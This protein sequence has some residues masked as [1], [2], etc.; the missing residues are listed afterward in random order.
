MRRAGSDSPLLH[1]G[2]GVASAAQRALIQVIPTQ[3]L[4]MNQAVTVVNTLTYK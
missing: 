2:D 3:S 4:C 1:F